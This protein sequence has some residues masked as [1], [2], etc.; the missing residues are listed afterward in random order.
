S[1][2]RPRNWRLL[3]SC[4]FAV[5]T[6]A[7]REVQGF[8]ESFEGWGYEDSDL[9]IRLMNHGLRI[10]RA[11]A[12][13]CVLHLWHPEQTRVHAGENLARLHTTLRSGR[14]LPACGLR[15]VREHA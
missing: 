15:H 4:N 12:A 1:R 2:L 5:P 10:E 9:C 7:F 6:A 8:D 14:T 3:R 11:P 13:C